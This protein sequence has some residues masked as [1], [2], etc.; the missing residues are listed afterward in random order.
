MS[1][2]TM[3][4]HLF[5]MVLNVAGVSS[6]ATAIE[7]T[8]PIAALQPVATTAQ[9]QITFDQAFTIASNAV[10]GDVIEA[11]FE[12]SNEKANDKYEVNIIAKGIEHEV[13][14]DANTGKVL[15]IKQEVLNDK[16]LAE[17]SAMKQSKISLTQAIE[18][19]KQTISGTVVEAEFDGDRGKSVYEIEVAQGAQL[20]KMV[21]DSMT[22]ALITNPIKIK[23][24]AV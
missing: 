7:Q 6:T 10:T 14:I 19:A 12:Q 23:N 22:G 9:R 3:L 13:N 24:K 17:Y 5:L 15:T 21:V 18:Q 16:G 1:T 4:N 2:L 20:H 8:T 11:E